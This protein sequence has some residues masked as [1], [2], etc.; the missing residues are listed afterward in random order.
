MSVVYT[1]EQMKA[2]KSM[3]EFTENFADQIL[4]IMR[5]HGLDLADGCDLKIGINPNQKL[6]N[7]M[8]S[9]GCSYKKDAGE[10][11][12]TRGEK[13]ER[14]IP[15]GK[16]SPEYEILFATEEMAERIRQILQR[17]K[18]L[19]PDGLWISSD[20]NPSPVDGGV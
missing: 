15:T 3:I 12:L 10:I 19:P 13:D 2:L 1:A 6:V 11:T 20:D 16:N 9:F 4:Y 14:Y 18:P 5:H 7:R 8:I 17:E